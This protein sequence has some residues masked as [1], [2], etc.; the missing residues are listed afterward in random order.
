M[1]GHALRMSDGCRAS[2]T[3]VRSAYPA[4]PG[5]HARGQG[6]GVGR[7]CGTCNEALHVLP[8][9]VLVAQLLVGHH[10]RHSG[11]LDGKCTLDQL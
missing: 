2:Q 1:Q 4:L 11:R 3:C 9:D 5:G 10:L 7:S 6:S 8:A